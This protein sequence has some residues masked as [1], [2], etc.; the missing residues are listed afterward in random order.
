MRATYSIVK[1]N[2]PAARLGRLD[3]TLEERAS[4]RQ[5]TPDL[6]AGIQREASI[7]AGF[8]AMASRFEVE[9]LH[10]YLLNYWT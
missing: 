5:N 10:W 6:A 8:A 9:L 7:P 3:K 4:G 2:A 1:E